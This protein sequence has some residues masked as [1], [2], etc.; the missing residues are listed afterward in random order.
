MAAVKSVIPEV[1]D[2]AAAEEFYAA[3]GVGAHVGVRAAEEP[4]TGFRAFTLSVVVSQP[5][6]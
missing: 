5:C 6:T 2:P 4:T 3:F 1:P